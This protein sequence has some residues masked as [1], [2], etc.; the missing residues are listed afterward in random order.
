[1]SEIQ[2]QQT[3]AAEQEYLATMDSFCDWLMETQQPIWDDRLVDLMEDSDM[4]EKYL[5]WAGLPLDTELK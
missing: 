5:D 2:H 3:V 1:M 4:Q